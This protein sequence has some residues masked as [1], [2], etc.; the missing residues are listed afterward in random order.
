MMGVTYTLPS[1]TPADVWTYSARKLSMSTLLSMGTAAV[2]SGAGAESAYVQIVAATAANLDGITISC[3][4]SGA[5]T[6]SNTVYV[7]VAIG[8]AG[9]E[10]V[11]AENVRFELIRDSTGDI[12]TQGGQIYL[13][14]IKILAGSRVAVRAKGT[15][16][17]SLTVEVCAAV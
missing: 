6:S 13:P 2:T 10:V 9:S 1:A 11:V 15:S 17:Q 5:M 8:A 12:F 7:D 16:A 14:S 4:V 3:M